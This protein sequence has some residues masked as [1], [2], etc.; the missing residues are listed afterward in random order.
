LSS[1]HDEFSVQSVLNLEGFYLRVVDTTELRKSVEADYPIWDIGLMVG[2]FASFMLPVLLAFLLELQNESFWIG[3]QIEN[4]L[5]IP[6][7]G[8][9]QFYKTGIQK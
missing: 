3:N 5:G 4:K 9:V 8:S 1:K 7:L 2:I 6:L